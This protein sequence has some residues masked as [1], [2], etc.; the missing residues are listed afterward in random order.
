MG[1]QWRGSTACNHLLCQGE[2]S[3]LS[4]KIDLYKNKNLVTSF[5]RTLIY[6][7]CLYIRYITLTSILCLE[8]Y[9]TL[10]IHYVKKVRIQASKR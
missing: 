5:N 9:I 1:P 4:S 7:L 3:V 6:L 8:A 2:E 10:K